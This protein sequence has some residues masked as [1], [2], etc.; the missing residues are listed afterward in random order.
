MVR[1]HKPED[2]RRSVVILPDGARGDRLRAPSEAEARGMLR[3]L[4][5]GLLKAEANPR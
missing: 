3:L 1:M 2:E 5:P 4:E